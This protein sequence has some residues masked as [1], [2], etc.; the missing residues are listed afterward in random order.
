MRTPMMKEREKRQ[1]AIV[2]GIICFVFW[3]IGSYGILHYS[4]VRASNKRYDASQ[5]FNEAMSNM[6]LHPT[7]IFPI[8]GSTVSMI[9]MVTLLAGCFIMMGISTNA[10]KKHDGA[11]VKGGARLMNRYDLKEYNL[12][13][14]DPPRKPTFNGPKNMILSKEIMLSLDNR[15]TKRNCNVLCIGGSGAGKSRYFA[16]PNILQYNANF[17][18]TDPSGELLSK[19]GKALEDNGY[20][21]KVFNLKNTYEGSRYN[22]FRY[23]YAEK[24][25]FIL[26]NTL[27]KNTTPPDSHAGDPFWEKCEKMLLQSLILFLWHEVPEKDQTFEKLLALLD[28]EKVDENDDDKPSPLKIIFD[29]LEKEAPDHLAVRQYKAFRV[30]AGKTLK[31]ILISVYARIESFM[32]ADIKYLTGD[33]DLD[34]YSFADTKQALFVILPTADTT[35]NFLA[36][37]MYSQLFSVLYDYAETRVHFGWKAYIP[38]TETR[39]EEI[40][41]IVQAP[42]EKN[43]ENAKKEIMAFVKDIKNGTKLVPNN[44]RKVWEIRTVKGNKLVAWRGGK[45]SAEK[46]RQELQHIEFKQCERELLPNHVRFILDEFA[47]IGQIPD[48]VQK[49]ATIRKY[50]ISCAIILQNISQL[51]KMYKDDWN[52]IT[53][54]CDS[55]LFLGTNDSETIKWMMEPLGKKTTVVQNVS[56]SK[57]GGSTSYNKDSI[58]LLTADQIFLMETMECLVVVRGCHPYYGK[59]YDLLNHPNFPYAD[60]TAGKFKIP[61]NEAIKNRRE[62]PRRLWNNS[63]ESVSNIAN[64]AESS[65]EQPKLVNDTQPK[66]NNGSKESNKKKTKAENNIPDPSFIASALDNGVKG[67][68]VKNIPKD[69]A[70]KERENST[71]ELTEVDEST[72]KRYKKTN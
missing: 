65:A 50:A 61:V 40:I 17:V 2:Y 51:K 42:S 24:D 71:F 26:V 3:L 43:I 30:A 19:Y 6:I 58:E 35:F 44:S 70:I 66:S 54:N 36:S 57:S 45:N 72:P 38:G 18:I 49:L 10:L 37:L 23:I 25:V 27:I 34:L 21:V 67:T 48:F 14:S 32:L 41:K 52:S 60:K 13:F 59:K 11:N 63:S 68:P 53:G 69:N 1:Q 29:D 15:E 12:T 7:N 4:A 9:F 46:L 22:P 47:N 39:L 16:A 62:G 55:W 20:H 8:S 28:M 31:S 64:S 56:W 5:C 33:D